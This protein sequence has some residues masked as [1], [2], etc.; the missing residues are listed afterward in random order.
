MGDPQIL[1]VVRIWASMAWA[2]GVL[3]DSEASA[4][5][6]L[7]ETA[8]LDGEAQ[9]TARTWLEAPV[10][11][12]ETGLAE[13]SAEARTGIYRAACRI[14]AVDQA[15]SDRERSLLSRLRAALALDAD[16]VRA[17]EAGIPGLP[18]S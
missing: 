10:D 1:T 6:R 9:A 11:L 7:I 16:Q 8:G 12:D 4:L 5:R 13:L 2:D 3:A 15:V 18:V 14:A 17:I